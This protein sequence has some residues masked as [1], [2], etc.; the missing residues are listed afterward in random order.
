[1][2]VEGL[3]GLPHL[4]S[5]PIFGDFPPFWR[6]FLLQRYPIFLPFSF[7]GYFAFGLFVGFGGLGSLCKIGVTYQYGFSRGREWKEEGGQGV[8]GFGHTF[9]FFPFFFFFLGRDLKI[10]L[11]GAQTGRFIALDTN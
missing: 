1:M 11:F 3:D 9:L 6:F 5:A 10:P 7:S 4:F 8:G 2:V